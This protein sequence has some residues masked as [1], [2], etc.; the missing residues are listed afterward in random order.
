MLGGQRSAQA[1]MG[2]HARQ[3]R[4]QTEDVVKS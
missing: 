4:L 3:L 2:A 1:D